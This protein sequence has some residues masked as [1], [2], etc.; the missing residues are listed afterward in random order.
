MRRACDR[1]LIAEA[2][3]F[4]RVWM[5]ADIEFLS[6]NLDA[7]AHPVLLDLDRKAR[8]RCAVKRSECGDL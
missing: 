7:K 2:A 1:G 5:C 6:V 4:F 3:N 8:P